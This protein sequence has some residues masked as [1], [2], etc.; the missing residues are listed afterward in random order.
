MRPRIEAALADDPAARDI[1]LEWRLVGQLQ[2]NKA[3][4]AARLF[5]AVES[6]DRPALVDTLARRAAD[7][8]KQLEVLIQV[9]LCG[10]DQKGGC[11]ADDLPSLVAR[12]REHESLRLRGLMTVPAAGN[13]PEDARPAFRRLRELRRELAAGDPSFAGAALSMG[14]SGDLEVAVEEGATLVRIGTALFGER[15]VPA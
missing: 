6:V 7:E 9:S 12:I 10:E 13:G 4:L 2:R 8:G 3:G 14:M 1:R 11:Q 15:L 5:D